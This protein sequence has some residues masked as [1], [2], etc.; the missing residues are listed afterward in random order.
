[1]Q[2]GGEVLGVAA[3]RRQVAADLGQEVQMRPVRAVG[4]ALAGQL[5][6]CT[7]FTGEITMGD[8]K[9]MKLAYHKK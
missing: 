9:N 5:C 2:G 4:G 8:L 7:Q 1:V 3:V 6:V